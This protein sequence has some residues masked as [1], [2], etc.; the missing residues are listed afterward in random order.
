MPDPTEREI[1]RHM[2]ERA[3]ATVSTLEAA[4]RKASFVRKLPEWPLTNQ[5]SAGLM[6]KLGQIARTEYDSFLTLFKLT[7][8]DYAGVSIDEIMDWYESREAPFSEK[9]RQEFPDAF[10]VASL[11][12][13]TRGQDTSVAVISKDG[14]FERACM[15]FPR[16]MYFPSLTSY[17]TALQST[18]KRLSSIQAAISSSKSRLRNFINEVFVDSNFI[19][20]ANW[21][22]EATDVRIVTDQL[23]YNVV[24]IG[25]ESSTVAFEGDISYS[26]FVSYNDLD[27]ATYD[28]G[29]PVFFHQR[30]EETVEEDA[31]ISGVL[32]M[33]TKD[34]GKSIE[35]LEWVALDQVDFTIGG[36]V[37]F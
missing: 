27:T 3:S 18:N 36:E 35:K 37:V 17:S 13:F 30:I 10:A 11:E 14:D 6:Y 8:L 9:K 24:A 26:V 19:I 16:L 12:C 28:R 4:A 31:W 15:R 25:E 34:L 1:K 20:D 29:E 5:S 23:T 2:A 7:R 33:R 22:G 21:D 32:M